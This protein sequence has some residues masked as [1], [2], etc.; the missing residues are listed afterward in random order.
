MQPHILEERKNIDF[1][2]LRLK[3]FI[4]GGDCAY[5]R[6]M[7]YLGAAASAPEAQMRP[8]FWAL[9]NQ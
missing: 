3:R 9:S 7:A 8:D 6:A 5:S 1:D 2:F 4:Q